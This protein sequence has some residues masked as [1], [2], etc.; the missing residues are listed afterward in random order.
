SSITVARDGR[1]PPSFRVVVW[2]R[3]TRDGGR[4]QRRGYG[5]ENRAAH[6]VV[7]IAPTVRTKGRR[8]A[9]PALLLSNVD[10]RPPTLVHPAHPPA[11]GH[12]GRFFLLFGNL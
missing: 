6:G 8:I 3:R 10:V 7:R 11:V 12:R 4:E 2:R 1:T 5:G 9:A